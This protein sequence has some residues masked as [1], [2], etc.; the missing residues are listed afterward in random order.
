MLFDSIE[1]GF[2]IVEVLLDADGQPRDYRFVEAN[3]AFY[4][5][6]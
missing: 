3:P 2:C 6:T 4:P 1:D 5:S